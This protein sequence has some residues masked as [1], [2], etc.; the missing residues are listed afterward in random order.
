M[1]A[2]PLVL[3][4]GDVLMRIALTAFAA[5]VLGL[6]RGEHGKAAGLRTTML[7]GLAACLAMIETNA[8]LSVAGKAADS[9]VTFDP[10]R[11]PLGILS[12]MGFIGGGAILRH[13]GLIVGVTTAANLWFVTVL[14]LCFGAGQLT[15][16][17]LGLGLG[18]SVLLGLRWVECV[19]A[20]DQKAALTLTYERTCDA[21]SVL[22]NELN[23][24][25]YAASQREMTITGSRC[26]E[27]FEVRWRSRSDP[28]PT[29]QAVIDFAG[30]D[31][32][33]SVVWAAVG[34]AA[35]E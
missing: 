17:L 7:V 3:M 9:F 28:N 13:D 1:S 30:A 10:M 14:G 8:L 6:N 16:G 26:E 18:L 27:K 20:R 5:A 22:L 2:M 31:G 23:S 21:A 25:G 29:P 32:V 4:W 19:I 35:P 11:L 12:G 33:I 24:A 15:L 34:A